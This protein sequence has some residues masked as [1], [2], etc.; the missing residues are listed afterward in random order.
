M[1]TSARGYVHRE[2]D[3]AEE[4]HEACLGLTEDEHAVDHAGEDADSE[5]TKEQ[6]LY[7]C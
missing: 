3:G 5:G 1:S 4:A 7:Q 6:S 2:G